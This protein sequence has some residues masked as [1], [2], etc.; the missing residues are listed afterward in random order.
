MSTSPSE[1]RL[2]E[3]EAV[4][5][6]YNER[7][8]KGFDE[9]KKLAEEDGQQSF[10]AQVAQDD[11]PL[12]F[13]CE[14]SDENCIKRVLMKPSDYDK[15]HKDRDTF[16]MVPGHETSDIERIVKKADSY[17]VV[18][19]FEEPSVPKNGLNQTEVDNT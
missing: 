8:I 19:K 11:R 5:R 18:E 6:E 7:I 12:Y 16:V 10:L 3:N 1:R 13:Y 2:A 4:F 17:Y 15:I 9:L 14:C